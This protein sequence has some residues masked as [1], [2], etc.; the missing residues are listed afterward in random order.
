MF[1]DEDSLQD[2]VNE[3]RRDMNWLYTLVVIIVISHLFVSFS[4]VLKSKRIE[5]IERKISIVIY[6]DDSH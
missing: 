4:S 6:Q 1:N 2:Q 3:I 5:A